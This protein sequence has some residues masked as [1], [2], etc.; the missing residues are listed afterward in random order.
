M[1]N[2]H[3]WDILCSSLTL[4]MCT[5][6]MTLRSPQTGKKNCLHCY[7]TYKNFW[8]NVLPLLTLILRALCSVTAM[9]MTLS[10]GK[11]ATLAYLIIS[12]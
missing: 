4:I 9:K 12:F 3:E 11:S 6:L 10:W 2:K 5:E 7:H 1:N 8:G